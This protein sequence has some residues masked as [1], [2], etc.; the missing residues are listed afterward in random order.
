MTSFGKYQVLECIGEGGF[1][2]VFRGYDP[3]L[4]RSVA[5]K[6]CTLREPT[7]RERFVREA[8]IAANLRHPNI[9]TV[10]D[11]GEHEGEP[12]IV[13]EYL[14]G[15]D[16]DH[17]IKREDAL[18]AVM[19]VG[20]L[21]QI[22]DGLLFAHGCGVAHRDVKPSNLRVLPDGQIRIMDFGIAKLL[23]SE[24]QLTKSGTSL[25]T[26]G[27]L[28]PE[29]L[30][31]G[32]IDHRVDIFSFGVVAY[33]LIARQ[34]PF[35]G[36]TIT[37]I[38]FR[39]AHEDPAPLCEV[40]PSCSPPQAALIAR[41]LQKAP[42]DR[43]A[44]FLPVIDELNAVTRELGAGQTGGSIQGASTALQLPRG[45]LP[46]PLPTG[47]PKRRL[48]PTAWGFLTATFAVAI[49]GVINLSR[50]GHSPTRDP[51]A[52]TPPM[53]ARTL[54]ATNSVA[55]DDK[56]AGVD[57]VRSDTTSK[58]LEIGMGIATVDSSRFAAVDSAKIPDPSPRPKTSA[59]PKEP[60]R[61]SVPAAALS[62]NPTRVVLL[63]RSQVQVTAQVAEAEL[64]EELRKGGYQVVDGAS[65]V[66]LENHDVHS[67]AANPIA[68]IGQANRAATVLLIDASSEA[69]AFTDAMYTGS[70][71]VSVKVYPT[72]TGEL[73]SAKRFE[74]GTSQT[75]GE[76]GPSESAAANAAVKAASYRA[77]RFLVTRLDELR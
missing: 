32:D 62:V 9:V 54:P 6:T 17:K 69:R 12:Y 55:N 40:A 58:S 26:A 25:G 66:G 63:V 33:E 2:R 10:Y 29:Q 15:E 34:R 77:A 18:G 11:F 20:W 41:C 46:E 28:A 73:D 49:L 36:D 1:G 64:S 4:K 7:M 39:I 65:A 59:V 8:E 30:R 45:S 21:R 44:S 35:E 5:I 43:F 38:M 16:L 70:A 47:Q 75:P 24:H 13:Q 74:I 71:L 48:S 56:A 52:V 19:V 53:E 72:S 23:Q 50:L 60:R 61:H 67:G 37:E 51:P 27:Y 76:L 22:A 68:G 31:G 3:V 42:Q 57:S 14:E